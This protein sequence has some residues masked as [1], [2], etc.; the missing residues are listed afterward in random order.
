MDITFN[1]RSNNGGAKRRTFI[2]IETA[3]LQKV[4]EIRNQ[5]HGLLKGRQL[6]AVRE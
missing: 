3:P 2:F 1:I 5:V 4:E 6:E